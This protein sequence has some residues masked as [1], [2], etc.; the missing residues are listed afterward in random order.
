MPAIRPGLR[1]QSCDN[2]YQLLQKCFRFC[3]ADGPSCAIAYK[4]GFVPHDHAAVV[5]EILVCNG[6][7]LSEFVPP[8]EQRAHGL[9]VVRV[10]AQH[11]CIRPSE[12]R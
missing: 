6:R 8:L 11:R 3:G 7:P 2:G 10:E 1:W 9:P 12:E 5:L 4:V